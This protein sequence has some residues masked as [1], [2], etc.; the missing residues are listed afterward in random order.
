MKIENRIK[1]YRAIY[2]MSQLELS[3]R[4]K[5]RRETIANLEYG[6]YN[7]SLLLAWAIAKEF[8]VTIEDI[9]TIHLNED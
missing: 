3:N 7:P 1:M 9:F 2:N 5:V 4:V 6:K 8:S